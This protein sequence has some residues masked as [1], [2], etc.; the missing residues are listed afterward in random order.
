MAIWKEAAPAKKEIVP[1]SREPVPVKEADAPPTGLP[2]HVASGREK[3]RE[4]MEEERTFTL[5]VKVLTPVAAGAAG[6]E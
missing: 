4:S 3:K 5:A 6:K 1:M 2:G